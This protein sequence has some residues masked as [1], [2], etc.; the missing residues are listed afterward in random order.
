MGCASRLSMQEEGNTEHLWAINR[1]QGVKLFHLTEVV[2]VGSYCRLVAKPRGLFWW[3]R[4]PPSQVP[5]RLCHFMHT[6]PSALGPRRRLQK[7]RSQALLLESILVPPTYLAAC[8]LPRYPHVIASTLY[9]K[10]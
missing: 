5:T 2:P 3:L 10:R 1:W 6:Y 8:P 9:T 7:K 4:V